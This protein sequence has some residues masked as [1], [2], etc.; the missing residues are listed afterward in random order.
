[1]TVIFRE[2]VEISV[3]RLP[4]QKQTTNMLYQNVI[5]LQRYVDLGA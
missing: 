4:V 1:M 2:G 5:D 3:I